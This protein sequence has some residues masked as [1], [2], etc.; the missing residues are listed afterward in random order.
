M[1][2]TARDRLQ[3][4]EQAGAVLPDENGEIQERAGSEGAKQIPTL[5]REED[6]GAA[7]EGGKRHPEL[8]PDRDVDD[9]LAN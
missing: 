2:G 4:G 6:D 7:H 3:E 8:R 9:E 1:A 5:Q